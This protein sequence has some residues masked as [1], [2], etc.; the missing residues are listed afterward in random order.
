MVEGTHTNTGEHA[1]STQKG[2]GLESNLGPSGC[3]AALLTTAAQ[4][5]TRIHSILMESHNVF[6]LIIKVIR[7]NKPILLQR[8]AEMCRCFSAKGKMDYL[9]AASLTC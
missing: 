2:P 1:K 4:I 8:S 7:E 9:W 3:E 6:A 5:R